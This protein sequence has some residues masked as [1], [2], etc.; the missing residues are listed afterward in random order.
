LAGL[1]GF[2]C[3]GLL[4]HQ[5]EPKFSARP[6][7]TVRQLLLEPL[8]DHKYRPT[9]LFLCY[10]SFAVGVSA[11]FFIAQL[12]KYH[13]WSFKKIA[14]LSIAGSLVSIIGNDFWG[15]IV[16][17]Y[18]R[19]PV[20]KITTL[21]I[22]HLPLYYAFC[23]ADVSW[24]IFANALLAPVFW[25]GF[26][27]A[28]FSL[29]MPDLPS[30]ARPPYFALNAALSGVSTFV[31]SSLAGLL[32][33]YLSGF[34]LEFLNWQFTHYQV[35]FI[36]SAVL[37]VP[38]FFMV[39]HLHDPGAKHSMVLVR[40]AF[41]EVNRWLGLGRQLVIMQGEAL[42]TPNKSPIEKSAS[43]SDDLR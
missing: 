31:A 10:W 13:D 43:E 21:G 7:L 24:P 12:L 36:L 41:I 3:F 32:A 33:V 39:S 23:P 40:Q 14:L 16:D 5:P 42:P 22:I 15:K 28:V 18:G 30:E 4:K 29:L 1:A 20:M 38:A 35:I 17:R 9:L 11:P 8:A 34:A 2:V 6:G 27:L 37:R 26:S 19:R 25:S